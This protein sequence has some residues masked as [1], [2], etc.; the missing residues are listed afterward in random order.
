[1]GIQQIVLLV[2]L[3][4]LHLL[5]FKGTNIKV[6]GLRQLLQNSAILECSISVLLNS[7]QLLRDEAA[8]LFCSEKSTEIMKAD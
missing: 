1:M 3:C 2:S 4:N 7:F 8:D 6:V 5:H